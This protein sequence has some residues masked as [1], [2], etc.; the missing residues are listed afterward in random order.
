MQDSVQLLLVRSRAEQGIS[1]CHSPQALVFVVSF[2]I[3][4]QIDGHAYTLV[5]HTYS[6]YTTHV[7]GGGGKE[8]NPEKERERE[9]EKEG[10]EHWL[11]DDKVSVIVF[12][13]FSVFK[14]I[15]CQRIVPQ[16]LDAK[17]VEI[18]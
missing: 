7:R 11:C 3:V 15:V 6:T 8:K 10:G 9:K 12:S 14:I 18:P 13:L 4:C 1:I 5:P 17:T 16:P 2:N